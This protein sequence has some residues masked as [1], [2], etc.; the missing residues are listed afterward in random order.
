MAL[1]D[2]TLSYADQAAGMRPN[3]KQP[4][5]PDKVTHGFD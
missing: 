1:A 3:A 5:I 4:A 2:L